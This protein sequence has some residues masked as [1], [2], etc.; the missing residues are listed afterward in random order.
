[1]YIYNSEFYNMIAEIIQDEKQII[2]YILAQ[3]KPKSIVDFG[4]GE[5]RWLMEAKRNNA[6]IEVL[7]LDGYYV[8]RDRLQIS[9]DEFIEVDL[10]KKIEFLQK[11][12]LAISTE[13]AEHIEEEYV[14]IFLD[15]LTRASDCILFSAAIPGQ[16]G[17][18]HVNEQWQS[19]WVKKFENLGYKADFSIRNYFWKNSNINAWRRQNMLI[20][21]KN[22][23]KTVY[24]DLMDVVHP[25]MMEYCI[26]RCKRTM[27]IAIEYMLRNPEVAESI[28]KSLRPLVEQKK[29]LII[30][31][32]GNNGRLCELI[33]NNLFHYDNFLIVD[34]K[35]GGREKNILTF[36]EIHNGYKDAVIFDVCSNA[37]IHQELLDAIRGNASE[38]ECIIVFKSSFIAENG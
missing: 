26:D 14:D 29:K 6:N 7:G 9:Q 19:Y 30:Y 24:S 15:N 8:D 38:M 27:G 17:R 22:L 1:M 31:P 21:S 18:H 5:G 25:E 16:G 37:S 20:F 35:Q 33:L 4:C 10:R 3:L 28:Q 36:D 13:V 32:Y 11:Y 12:D 23:N 34:N 2:P